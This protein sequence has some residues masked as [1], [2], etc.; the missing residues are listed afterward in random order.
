MFRLILAIFILGSIA[1][2]H[3]FLPSSVPRS[4]SSSITCIQKSQVSVRSATSS[5]LFAKKQPAPEPEV[6]YWEGEWIC[7]DCGYIY[8]R[9]DCGDFYFEQQPKGF[10]CPQCAGPRRRFAKKIGDKVGTT[11]DGGDAPILLF[12]YGG[13]ALVVGF[14]V[15]A[16]LDFPGL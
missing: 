5:S 13:L 2:T 1:S 9:T 12:S 11:L 3:A 4:L 10:K 14:G 6:E 7:A 8:D 16:A 15:W